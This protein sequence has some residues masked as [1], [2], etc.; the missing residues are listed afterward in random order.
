M[1]KNYHGTCNEHD[2]ISEVKTLSRKVKRSFCSGKFFCFA[3]VDLYRCVFVLNASGSFF[4]FFNSSTASKDF[5][6]E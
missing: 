3:M 4:F 5:P 2:R 6:S 1:T